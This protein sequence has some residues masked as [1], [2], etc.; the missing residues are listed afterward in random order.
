MNMVQQGAALRDSNHVRKCRA[1]S[2][3]SDENHTSA[4]SASASDRSARR[5]TCTSTALS[6]FP[7]RYISGSARQPGQTG[8]AWSTRRGKV[9]HGDWLGVRHHLNSTGTGTGTPP[10]LNAVPAPPAAV[11]CAPMALQNPTETAQ[12]VKARH[13]PPTPLRHFCRPRG[14]ETAADAR[15]CLPTAALTRVYRDL[16]L[17]SHKTAGSPTCE[18][19][20]RHNSRAEVRRA[21]S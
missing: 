1:P 19:W 13:V 3:P 11:E 12:V 6:A 4:I 9:Q 16:L 2:A 18:R 15:G 5:A 17:S 8:A 7:Q 14:K 21:R 20:E 10:D